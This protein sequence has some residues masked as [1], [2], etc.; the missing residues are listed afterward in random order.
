LF[1]DKQ[2]IRDVEKFF[3]FELI[4]LLCCIVLTGS[5]LGSYQKFTNLPPFERIIGLILWDGY[6]ISHLEIF[7]L[8]CMVWCAMCGC[9]FFRLVQ[10]NV[11]EAKLNRIDQLRKVINELNSGSA[12]Q[13]FNVDCF[14]VLDRPQSIT[15]VENFS[16]GIDGTVSAR[17]VVRTYWGRTE[18]YAECL[19][20]RPIGQFTYREDF[21]GMRLLRHIDR[22]FKVNLFPPDINPTLYGELIPDRF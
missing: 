21:P 20:D 9:L 1:I 8:A 17:L 22:N 4:I 12:P 3:Q 14:L 2:Q 15:I 5:S 7:L 19:T 6:P 13:L 18:E 11:G 16:Q 10:E